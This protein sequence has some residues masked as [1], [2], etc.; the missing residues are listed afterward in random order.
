MAGRSVILGGG[1][2]VAW[3]EGKGENNELNGALTSSRG[4]VMIDSP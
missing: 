3:N 4:I 2:M 1:T